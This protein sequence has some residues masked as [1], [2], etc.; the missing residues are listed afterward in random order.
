MITMVR[1][2]VYMSDKGYVLK[3]ER[4][5]RVAV[6][7][8]SNESALSLGYWEDA[9]PARTP[10]EIVEREAALEPVVRPF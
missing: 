5:G 2:D 9:D 8:R 3:R 10:A 4:D 6:V 1:G 7:E